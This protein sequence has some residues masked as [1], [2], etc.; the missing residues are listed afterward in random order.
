M[1]AERAGRDYSFKLAEHR[2]HVVAGVRAGEHELYHR[3]VLV[4]E[5]YNLLSCDLSQNMVVPFLKIRVDSPDFELPFGRNR[6]CN[7]PVL[8]L[9][10]RYLRMKILPRYFN[11]LYSLYDAGKLKENGVFIRDLE[12]IACAF[13]LHEN[14]MGN[15]SWRRLPLFTTMNSLR[16]SFEELQQAVAKSGVLYFEGSTRINVKER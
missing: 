7:E 16:L 11:D 8:N 15:G 3:N 9:L 1:A 14:L 13:L 12:E 10:S 4:S 6:I 2:F 5:K